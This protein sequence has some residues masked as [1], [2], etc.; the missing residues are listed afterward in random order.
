MN[1][2][3]AAESIARRTICL[4]RYL[5][6]LLGGAVGDALGYPVEFMGEAAIR[7]RYGP[8]GIQTLGEAGHP[9]PI[10][11]D[12]QMTLFAANAIVYA[13]KQKTDLRAALWLAWREWLGTQGDTS[14][15][16][17][18][19]RPRMWLYD[20]LR[21][22]AL[23][24]PG[25]TCLQA[26]RTS[27]E[28][29]TMERPVNNSKGCGTV[30]R[31]APFGLAVH[32]E[33]T[34]T[35]KDL[36]RSVHHMA[37][38]D[39]ALTHGHPLAWASSSLLAQLVFYVVQQRPDRDYRLEEAIPQMVFPEDQTARKLLDRAVAL[40]LDHTI[41]DLDGIHALGEG[42]VAE[43]ALAIALFCAVRHQ[44]DFAAAIR[45]AVN[46]K[47]DSDSTGA[48]CGNLLG[49]WLGK[50]AVEAAFDLANLELRDVIEEVAAQLFEAVEG[51]EPSETDPV[52]PLRPV[53]LM[54]TPLAKK[55]LALCF[56]AH[57]NQRDRSGLPYVFHPFHLAEQMET[58]EEVCTALLHDVM[59][60]SP[61]TLED[62]RQAGFPAPVL[63]ALELLTRDPSTPYL[64]YVARLRNNPIAR[65]VKLADLKHNSDLSRLE[66]PTEADRQRVLKYRMAQAILEGGQT[67]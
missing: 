54:Y 50:E 43:E 13:K 49:A 28:G 27:P 45:S 24:A 12:T 58:E 21:L 53:G 9:A 1:L 5:G 55:A 63:E 6:C 18:P 61:C 20:Q 64:A 34:H 10:S 35:Q 52:A 22:H 23:R 26:I 44:N 36:I 17:D 60:D 30:M 39:A 32:C 8:D 47:G 56:E 14:R 16:E 11:D 37:A 59:E 19:A 38:M 15:M 2:N 67:E 57:K 25:N 29:G 7:A 3:A 66:D 40:A 48:I 42:W 31:A 33:S 4:D 62:L 51:P 41:S 46:H 65:R